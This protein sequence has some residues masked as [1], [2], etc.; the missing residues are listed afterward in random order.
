MKINV[1]ITICHKC[2]ITYA[3]LALILEK[4][5]L[6]VNSCQSYE[7][8]MSLKYIASPDIKISPPPSICTRINLSP[9]NII[10]RTPTMT[11]VAIDISVKYDAVAIRSVR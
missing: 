7:Y 1:I 3:V 5:I 4:C 8:A 2:V 9:K 6:F 10:A 11:G